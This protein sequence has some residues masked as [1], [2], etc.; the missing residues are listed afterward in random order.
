M[1]LI[2][3]L[4]NPGSGYS[5][6]RHNIGFICLNYFARRNTI[7]WDR[8]QANARTGT[9]LFEGDSVL[10]AK[11]QAYMNCSGHSVNRLVNKFKIN[12]NDLIVIHDDLDLPLSRIRIRQGGGSGGHKGINSIISE[13]GS[14]EFIRI[15]FGIGRPLSDEGIVLTDE[16]DIVDFVL[17]DFTTDEQKSIET[18]I[19]RVSEAIT[20]LLSEGLEVAMNRYN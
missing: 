11:P 13:L 18:A 1:K 8:K 15:R 2:V 6:N 16:A 12:I 5:R 10:L 9:G 3:G 19:I 17:S 20:C 4:G 7:R 14:R